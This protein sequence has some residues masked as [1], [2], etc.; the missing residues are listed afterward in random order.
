MNGNVSVDDSSPSSSATASRHVRDVVDPIAVVGYSL[1]FPADATNA[2]SFWRMLCE[3][4]LAVSK[5]PPDRFN[6]DYF[7]RSDGGRLDSVRSRGRKYSINLTGSLGTFQRCS[8]LAEDIVTFDAPSFA[9]T[10]SESVCM[11]PQQRLLLQTSYTAL[12]NGKP[13]PVFFLDRVI[14]DWRLTFQL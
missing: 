11:D 5:V 10:P 3:G 7:Y 13:F 9:I 6:V 14:L 12:E 2:E 8:F 1:K 4:M